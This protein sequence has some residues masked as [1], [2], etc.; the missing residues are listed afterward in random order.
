MPTPSLRRT[1]RR[2]RATLA[3]VLLALAGCAGS[4]GAAPSGPEADGGTTLAHARIAEDPR[5]LTGPTTAVLAESAIDPVAT[6]PVPELP[7]TLTDMQGTEVTVSDTSRILALDVY[8]SISRIV[9]ELGLGDR[10]VG[11]GISSAFA[12]IADRPLVTSNGHELTAEAILDL[13]PTVILTDTS[14][15]PWDVLLQMRDAG[16][17]VVVLDPQRDI[18]S[19]PTLIGSVA[20]A[21]GVPTLGA[22]LAERTEA[23]VQA[24]LTEI[25]AI[26]PQDPSEKLRMAFLYVR[27][28]SGVYYMFGEGSGADALVTALGGLDVSGETGLEGMRPLNDEGLVKAAPDVILMMTK[29]LESVGGVDGLLEQLPAVASTPAGAA[30]RIV[31]MSDSSILSFGPNTADVLDALAVAIYA[32]PQAAA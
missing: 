27:G 9:F 17:P 25:A 32:E 1:S 11:R 14:L 10:V 13:A 2:H 6:D 26:A 20:E 30:R 31:D 22:L 29:G 28:Q 3:L 24:K 15:G 23:S 19:I 8:G 21:L 5:A 7:V 16:I 4:P 18:S 12:E